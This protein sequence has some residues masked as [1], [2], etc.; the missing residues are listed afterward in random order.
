V[1]LQ[2]FIVRRALL[3][4]ADVQDGVAVLEGDEVERLR[5]TVPDEVRPLV[6]EFNRLLAAMGHASPLAM[7]AAL[8]AGLNPDGR[9]DHRWKTCR[10]SAR[11]PPA[12]WPRRE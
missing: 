9:C 4:P 12:G 7:I 10:S 2:R 8:F 1:L 3:L 5:E 6:A 11:T